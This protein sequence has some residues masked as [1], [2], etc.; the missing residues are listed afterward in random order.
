[1]KE[2]SGRKQKEWRARNKE[3]FPNREVKCPN[4]EM[5]HLALRRDEI[6]TRLLSR[7]TQRGTA[8]ALWLSSGYKTCR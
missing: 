6:T 8:V 3:E 1:M 5:G 2:N 4:R 7:S